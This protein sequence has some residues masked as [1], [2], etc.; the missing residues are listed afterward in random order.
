MCQFQFGELW[1]L[2]LVWEALVEAERR[3]ELIRGVALLE[4][5]GE[6]GGN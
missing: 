2:A 6:L 4:A 3:L 5:G 1:D